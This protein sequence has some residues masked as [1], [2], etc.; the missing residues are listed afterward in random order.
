MVKILH[1]VLFICIVLELSAQ[2]NIKIQTISENEK[3]AVSGVDVILFN[4]SDTNKIVDFKVTDKNGYAQFNLKKLGE[5]RLKVSCLGYISSTIE[6]TTNNEKDTILLPFIALKEDTRL[7][8]EIKITASRKNLN[9]DHIALTF[10]S[11][12]IN[13]AKNASELMLNIPHVYFN[14]IQNS[15]STSDNKPILI[16]INGIV[17]SNEDLKLIPAEKVKKAEYYNVPSVRYFDKGKVLSI[18]TKQLDDGWAGD[19]YLSS[20]GFF[21]M[22]TPIVSYIKNNQKFSLGYTLFENNLMNNKR[23]F[24]DKSWNYS[25]DNKEYIY[26][27]KQDERDFNISHNFEFTYSRSKEKNYSFQLKGSFGMSDIKYDA[28]KKI[29][30]SLN[31]IVD[32]K[33]GFLTSNTS[34]YAPKIDIYYSKKFKSNNYIDLN[35]V[36]QNSSTKQLAHSIEGGVNSFEENMKS[37]SSKTTIIG[38]AAYTAKFLKSR[39]LSGYRFIGW[40]TNNTLTN[41]LHDNYEYNNNLN[42]HYIY[43]ELSRKFSKFSYRISLGGH[44][45]HNRDNE[46]Q[47]QLSFSPRVMLGYSFNESNILSA[48][49]N[50]EVNTPG[51]ADLSNNSIL[52]MNDIVRTGNPNLLSSKKHEYNLTFNRS[53][54]NGIYDIEII[55]AYNLNNKSIYYQFEERNINGKNVFVQFPS[56]ASKDSELGITANL[57]L[58]PLKGLRIG[59]SSSIIYQSFRANPN[60]STFSGYFYPISIFASYSYKNFNIDYSQKFKSDYLNALFIKGIEPISYIALSYQYKSFSFGATAYFPFTKNTFINKTTP[61]SKIEIL[62]SYQLKTKETTFGISINWSFNTSKKQFYERRKLDNTPESSE[63]FGVK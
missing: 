56:N 25:I 54:K 44:L 46:K 63:S 53:D 24:V 17:S 14:K 6:F 31:N 47:S 18:T 34:S 30:L 15:I 41:A 37:N 11:E 22:F 27:A 29:V 45:V 61:Q 26:N 55:A 10:N 36:V 42:S 57:T 9:L 62:E 52:I 23:D 50:S 39:F 43:S 32:N 19:F 28:N 60:Q 49:Y 21:S 16:L 48:N 8:K 20:S 59:S 13:K 3:K 33:L 38:E 4:R 12:Q 7:I 2:Q 35:L 1:L 5:W 51:T 40:W 58:H